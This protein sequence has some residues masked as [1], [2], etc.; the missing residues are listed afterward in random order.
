[1]IALAVTSAGALA[2]SRAH[3]SATPQT[4][5][6]VRD[7]V[8]RSLA[9]FDRRF[10]GPDFIQVDY[11]GDLRDPAVAARLLRLT[12]LLE[13]SGAFPD[14]RSVAQ[15]LGFLS[16]GFGGVHRVP[17][18]RESLANLWFFLEGRPDVKN[19]ASDARD[20]AMVVLRVPSHPDRPI[21]ELEAVVNAAV[22]DSLQL[23]PAGAKR[24]LLGLARGANVP[25]TEA[26]VDQVLGT[27]AAPDSPALDAE[28]HERLKTWLASTDSPYQPS[29]AEWSRLKGALVAEPA[30]RAQALSAV[31]SSFSS[32][33]EPTMAAQLVSSIES[34]VK[35]LRLLLRAQ[36]LADA[37]WTTPVP[38]ALKVRSQGVLADLLDA[39]HGTGDAATVVVSGLPVVAAT[40][41][42][43]LF[44]G[45]WRALAALVGV[46][47]VVWLLARRKPGAAVR[48]L[49]EAATASALTLAVVTSLGPGVDSGSA[50]LM[51]TPAL[52]SLLASGSPRGSRL[53]LAFMGA[54][55]LSCFTLLLL[56]V[57]PVVRI[58]AAMGAGLVV[59]ALVQ[60]ESSRFEAPPSRGAGPAGR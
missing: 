48:A 50:M 60:R 59:A 5:F 47:A 6:T 13:G 51:L 44:G 53:T 11:R 21:A 9:F 37:L 4:M 31:A 19:L 1:L 39:P 56:D 54:L 49:L 41:E 18:T 23:G 46:G 8:G 52:V 35:E 17:P 38:E 3:F 2:A 25:L 40:L 26:Q 15:I 28:V 22:A 36:A 57:L 27:V 55:G 33:S 16:K 58:G 10:G 34:R 24:R 29:E 20:E 12:D 7:D 42:R 14:V 45:L 43:D 30:A 32:L